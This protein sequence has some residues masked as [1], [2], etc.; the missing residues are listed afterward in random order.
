[1]LGV[2]YLPVKSGSIQFGKNPFFELAV[3]NTIRYVT[4]ESGYTDH[5]RTVGRS[6]YC[7]FATRNNFRRS[8]IG[9]R[10]G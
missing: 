8:Y 2:L 3:E 10:P 5:E 9:L 7:M 1:M 6:L 4:K